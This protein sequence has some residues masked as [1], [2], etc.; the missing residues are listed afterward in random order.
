MAFPEPGWLMDMLNPKPAPYT[1]DFNDTFSNPMIPPTQG[2]PYGMDATPEAIAARAVQAGIAPPKL[3]TLGESL[4]A[5]SAK[6]GEPQGNPFPDPNANG[7]PQQ[8]PNANKFLDTL[9]GLKPPAQATPMLPSQPAAQLHKPNPIQSGQLMQLMQ[10]MQQ[11]GQGQPNPV[12]S[13]RK[14]V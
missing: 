3:P 14:A 13:L 8:A 11:A 6:A 9:K 10:M 2:V 12:S 4:E 5:S 1:P 7:A